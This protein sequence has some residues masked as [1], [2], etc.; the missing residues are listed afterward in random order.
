M[1]SESQ[2]TKKSSPGSTSYSPK[3]TYYPA[4]QSK[5]IYKNP[6]SMPEN[7]KQRTHQDVGN[8]NQET[9]K[10]CLVC[11]KSTN[12]ESQLTKKSSLRSTSYSPTLLSSGTIPDK[13]YAVH[14]KPSTSIFSKT[15]CTQSHMYERRKNMEAPTICNT[16]REE[17]L[18]EKKE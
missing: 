11:L 4:V 14:S 1:N 17:K 3:K 7:R 2:L 6:P 16:K 8:T 18:V 15:S 12:S 9:K 10:E 5:R 13:V